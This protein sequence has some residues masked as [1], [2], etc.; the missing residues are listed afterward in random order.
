MKNEYSTFITPHGS[1]IGVPGEEDNIDSLVNEINKGVKF[2]D[3]SE[4]EEKF[5]YK[6]QLSIN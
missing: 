5:A 1:K 3:M 4:E 6:K 2:N